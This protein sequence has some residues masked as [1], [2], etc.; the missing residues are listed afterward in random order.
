VRTAIYFV[1]AGLSKALE[2]APFR[3]PVMQDFVNVAASYV[4]DDDVILTT[5]A[6]FVK[7]GWLQHPVS[8]R[9]MDIA[10]GLADGRGRAPD[11]R[12]EFARAM[13]SWPPENLETML[14]TGRDRERGAENRSSWAINRVF[15]HIGWHVNWHPL[16]RFL[17]R[18]DGRSDT[19]HCF[20]SFNY[21]LL[22]DHALDRL[23]GWT[24]GN[25]YGLPIRWWASAREGE[26][27]AT[28]MAQVAGAFKP[29]DVR[30]LPTSTAPDSRWTLLKPHGSLN[31][32]LTGREQNHPNEDELVL[33]LEDGAI[34]YFE[35]YECKA[36][37]FPGAAVPIEAALPLLPPVSDKHELQRTLH[38]M[39][40]DREA[41]VLDEAAEGYVIG[42][43][44]P[45]TDK[46]QCDLVR[47]VMRR[48]RKPLDKLTVVTLGAED[49]YFDRVAD[50]FSIRRGHVERHNRGFVDFAV[51]SSNPCRRWSDWLRQLAR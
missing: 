20:V 26:G 45:E 3:V 43:S 7:N 19:H 5:L 31:W 35:P 36:L 9:L 13:K 11:L 6:V 15:C 33:V 40:A 38:R 10:P 30:S 2:R 34:S 50:M 44:V 16:E 23:T 47:N 46:Q 25:G 8:R 1:G 27:L 24:Y 14:K 41:R 18:L 48:R 17:Q 42:W 32:L 21:D 12:N 51:N 28:Q 39:Q 22:L 49:V 4:E 29:V 37:S